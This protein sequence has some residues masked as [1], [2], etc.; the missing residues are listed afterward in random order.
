MMTFIVR[1]GSPKGEKKS[2]ITV[3]KIFDEMIKPFQKFIDH[4]NP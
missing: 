1:N 4:I 2:Y 3:C